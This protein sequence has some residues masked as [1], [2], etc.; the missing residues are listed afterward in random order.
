MTAYNPF[1]NKLII[2]DPPSVA[3]AAD[4]R[5]LKLAAAKRYSVRFVTL[6]YDGF[7]NCTSSAVK[8]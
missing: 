8:A 1:I 6:P 7:G 3:A 5:D 4:N 2:Y